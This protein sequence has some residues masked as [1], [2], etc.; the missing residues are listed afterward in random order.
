VEIVV[1]FIV[2][3]YIIYRLALWWL[4]LSD[5]SKFAREVNFWFKFA[6]IIA[7]VLVLIFM[8]LSGPHS[9]GCAVYARGPDLGD[10]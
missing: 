5:R 4:D 8:W 6:G 10:C 2:G 9:G 3:Y 1:G 7:I